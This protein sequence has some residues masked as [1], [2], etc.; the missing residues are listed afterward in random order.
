MMVVLRGQ[1]TLHKA[2]GA[3]LHTVTV[4]TI[5]LDTGAFTKTIL[6]QPSISWSSEVR[7][8]SGLLKRCYFINMKFS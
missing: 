4:T 1:Q 3:K 2:L 5:L 7:G 8:S 6:L